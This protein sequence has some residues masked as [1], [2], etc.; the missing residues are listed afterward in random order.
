MPGWLSRLFGRRAAATPPYR[1]A[2]V[3]GTQAPA[4]PVESEPEAQA[5]S[6]PEAQAESGP[7]QTGEISP[8]R[9]DAALHRLR[10]EIPAS[11]E[12]TA[13]DPSA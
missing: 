10:E 8:A 6:E 12:E 5:D 7:E 2:L 1:P 3:S 9:L 4:P 13:E 11:S